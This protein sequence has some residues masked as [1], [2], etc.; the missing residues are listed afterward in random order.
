MEQASFRE[1]IE[2]YGRAFGS[3]MASTSAQ[4]A[5]QPG[6]SLGGWRNAIHYRIN[7]TMQKVATF[8][9]SQANRIR[10]VITT[11]AFGVIQSVLSILDAG[12]ARNTSHD[13][14]E[15]PT[16]PARDVSE[17]GR[18]QSC[19]GTAVPVALAVLSVGSVCHK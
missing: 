16:P 7:S 2:F 19:T 12:A 11:L 6:E 17:S 3:S 4:P 5:D 14:P 1:S 10:L 15:D 8:S 18:H 9:G 13:D